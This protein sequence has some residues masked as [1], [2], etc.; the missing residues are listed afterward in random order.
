MWASIFA[1]YLILGKFKSGYNY[2]DEENT[3]CIVLVDY[4]IPNLC[5]L[6]NSNIICMLELNKC[7]K[8]YIS[9]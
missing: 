8:S 7:Y 6:I 2:F 4:V 9:Y 5:I 3:T 1:M